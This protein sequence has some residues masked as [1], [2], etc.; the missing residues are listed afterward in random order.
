M[1]QP[2][3]PQSQ[4]PQ[5]PKPPV[6]PVPPMP[7]QAPVAPQAPQAPKAPKA[8]E[9]PQAPVPPQNNEPAGKAAEPKAADTFDDI[10]KEMNKD[11]FSFIDDTDFQKIPPQM[12]KKAQAPQGQAPVPPQAPKAPEA[13]QAPVPPQAP[14]APAQQ[15]TLGQPIPSTVSQIQEAPTFDPGVPQILMEAAEKVEAEKRARREAAASAA[16]AAA[17]P[18][19]NEPVEDVTSLVNDSALAGNKIVPRLIRSKTGE[20]IYI[21]KPEFI[22]GK[23]KLHADYAIEH[24]TAVSRE[25]CIVTREPSGANYIVDNKST[26]GTYVNG[27]RIE[28]GK[29]QLLTDGTKVKLGDEEFIFKLRSG[30]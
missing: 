9:A 24:N 28:A 16:A 17:G 4:A 14:K 15:G 5:A 22:I 2:I 6:P 10:M 11:S 21:T 19:K 20:N 1:G 23:S 18:V 25:H 29:K 7:P 13:P 27:T 3:P 8:P 30:D 26:N 12:M